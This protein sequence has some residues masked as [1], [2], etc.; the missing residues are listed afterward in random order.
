MLILSGL[1]KLLYMEDNNTYDCN[2]P[3]NPDPTCI[4]T[5]DSLDYIDT[6]GVSAT[7]VR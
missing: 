7:L 3:A 6:S 1:S 5:G 2:Y 4:A